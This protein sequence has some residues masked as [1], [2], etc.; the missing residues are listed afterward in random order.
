MWTNR[1]NIWTREQFS[2]TAKEIYSS[3]LDATHLPKGAVM[4]KLEGKVAVVTGG[5]S[6]MALASAKR[7]VEE[8]A[9]VFI[10]GR[11]QEQLDEASS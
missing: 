1:Q 3:V 8:G 2:S 11:R 10:T 5:S 7:F 4:G 6:G 9:Y